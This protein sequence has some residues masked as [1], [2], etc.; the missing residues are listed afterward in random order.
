MNGN[1]GDR[2]SWNNGRGTIVDGGQYYES[3]ESGRLIPWVKVL[4]DGS[5]TIKIFDGFEEVAKLQVTPSVEQANREK[6]NAAAR[7]RR[8]IYSDLGLKR[9]RGNLGGI[10]YE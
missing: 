7:A 9:V 3:A 4:E 8:Q 2:V 5:D 10:Y 1:K 6:R